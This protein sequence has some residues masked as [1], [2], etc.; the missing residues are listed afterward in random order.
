[1]ATL[2]RITIQQRLAI[3]VG[4]IVLGLTLIKHC[5]FKFSISIIKR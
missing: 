1:M 5:N 2:R 3:L 4:L